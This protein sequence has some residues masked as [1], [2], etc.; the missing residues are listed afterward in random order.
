MP[1]M[2]DIARKDTM[3]IANRLGKTN[4]P[5]IVLSMAFLWPCLIPTTYYA[6]IASNT[7]APSLVGFPFFIVF[8]SLLIGALAFVFILGNRKQTSGIMPV[9]ILAVCG[10]LGVLG[11]VILCVSP[12]WPSI[13][14]GVFVIGSALAAIYVTS[15]CILVG[16]MLSHGEPGRVAIEAVL[17]FVIWELVSLVLNLAGI[18]SGVVLV[19]SPALAALFALLA[20][21]R[22]GQSP[23]IRIVRS[24]I[25]W[26]MIIGGVALV[27]FN[28]VYV[29]ILFAQDPSTSDSLHVFTSL[30]TLVVSFGII[31]FLKGTSFSASTLVMVFATLIILYIAALVVVLLIT[32]QANVVVNRLWAASGRCFKLFV[33]MALCCLVSRKSLSPIA[34][35]GFF[36]L[37]LVAIPDF[38]S[39]DLAYQSPFLDWIIHT[40]IAGPL[41]IIATFI[42]AA[43]S[44]V[45]LAFEMMKLSKAISRKQDDLYQSVLRAALEN[46]DLSNREL[47]VAEY[48]YR[49]YSAK[50]TAEALYLSESTVN[51]HTRNLYRKL[52]IHSKQDLIQ[53]VESFKR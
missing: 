37:A 27:F 40:D 8:P 34:A 1:G 5:F 25:P 32:D 46:R 28:I 11:H 45:F 38:V 19:L 12:I 49:G 2:S 42:T 24:E 53:L 47:Q 43:L 33:F 39:F 52:G 4:D 30:V 48:V 15:Y 20:R 23:G 14:V 36:L 3:G 9:R 51:S 41:A 10:A 31:A 44:I 18:D 29:K 7:T 50:R 22:P 21:P 6:T 16:G 35:F 13:P 26:Y 17:S